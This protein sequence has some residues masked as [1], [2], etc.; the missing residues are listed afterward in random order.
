MPDNTYAEQWQTA[1]LRQ[2]LREAV[3]I[4]FPIEDWAKEEGIADEE[5]Q[6]RIIRAVDEAQASRVT[7][8]GPD[9]FRQIEKAVLLQTLDH[10][11]REHLVTL[12]HLRQ[13]IG[14]RGYAQRDPLN[15]YKSEAFE[16]F[17]GML[18]RLREV[19]TQ[20][21]MR[22]EL[23]PPE[24]Q[25]NPF[26]GMEMVH[27]DPLTGENEMRAADFL[28]SQIPE[29]LRPAIDPASPETWGKVGRNEPCPC[30][31]GKKYKHCHGQFV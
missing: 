13:V 22:I 31:S 9:I 28:A 19:T 6:E 23:A 16:L 30:G 24:P 21:L 8:I 17:T 18:S 15:E 25:D 4:D 26:D 10:L 2:H 12:D 11:W 20:Q 14:W 1:E 3:A 29:H 27:R 5:M 7:R